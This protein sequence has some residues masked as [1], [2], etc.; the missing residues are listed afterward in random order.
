M[1]KCAAILIAMIK[2]FL[3]RSRI[4][5]CCIIGI[6]KY[7]R[8][9]ALTEKITG[10]ICAIFF[11]VPWVFL[12]LQGGEYVYY[13]QAQTS[14]LGHA[15]AA[16][17][18]NEPECGI[19]HPSHNCLEKIKVKA[20]KES[21]LVSAVYDRESSLK[22]VDIKNI[23]GVAKN[24]RG[25]VLYTEKH[26]DTYKEGRLFKRIS[27]FYNNDGEV[28]ATIESDFS[29]SSCLPDYH[30][31]NKASDSEEILTKS[32]NDVIVKY[33]SPGNTQMSEKKFPYA[34]ELCS[35]FGVANLIIEKQALII[36]D[37]TL[38]IK[39]LPIPRMAIYPMAIE[40][41]KVDG[42]EDT[43][44]LGVKFSLDLNL[45]NLLIPSAEFVVDKYTNEI[46]FYHGPSS[47]V[48]K[49]DTRPLVWVTYSLIGK[50]I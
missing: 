4:F 5:Q 19:L 3:S 17:Q 10:V 39:F 38:H 16:Q 27:A 49:S 43:K 29:K 15:K 9:Y 50:T 40:L 25:V 14:N 35:G 18:Y 45:L 6:S 28:I 22:N 32:E 26:E 46:V 20:P 34:A 11:F 21:P 48:D 13:L 47:L 30:L 44:Y 2:N 33:R 37:E 31:I 12:P 36:N 42:Y 7:D 24:K 23:L 41:A 1:I 8:H